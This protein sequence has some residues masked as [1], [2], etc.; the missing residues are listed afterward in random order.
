MISTKEREILEIF[1]LEIIRF[2]CLSQLNNSIHYIC[3]HRNSND[4][5]GAESLHRS[6]LVK[7]I[8]LIGQ[9]KHNR[10]RSR[11]IT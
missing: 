4:I 9:Y 7:V 10:K 6:K 1:A 2:K 11:Y 3:K 5:L 8:A